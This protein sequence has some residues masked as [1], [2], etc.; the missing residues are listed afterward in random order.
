MEHAV[1]V[2]TDHDPEMTVL[3]IDGIG[4]HDHV[5]RS[6]ILSKLYEIPSLCS[7]LPFFR[8]TYARASTCWWS[9]EDGVSHRIGQ[10]EGGEQG[11]PLMALLFSVAVHNALAE[12]KEQLLDGEFLFA[13]LDDVHVMAKP[14]RIR[15][16]YDLFTVKLSSMAGICTQGR[17]ARGTKR[18][19]ALRGWQNWGLLYGVMKASRSSEFQLAVQNSFSAKNALPR[20]CNCG[21]QSFGCQIFKAVGKSSSSVPARCHHFLRTLPLSESAWY[22]RHH[23]AGM[24]EEEI[25]GGLPG[26]EVQKGRAKE[27]A[28][29]PMRL[30]GLGLR[31]AARMAPAAFWVSWA[32]ALLLIS[33][34]LPEVANRVTVE[35]TR[36]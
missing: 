27:I 4:A 5:Y 29:M 16:I 8:K 28:T 15:T 25:L 20:R 35:L 13:F 2:V 11:D 23:D 26:D 32:D 1:R 9:D 34:R 31:S 10:H 7:L 24:M 14:D 36:E 30:G 21:K 19:C 12:V 17:P 33:K 6:S 3:S 22:A 18:E